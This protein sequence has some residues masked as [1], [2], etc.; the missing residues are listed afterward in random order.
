[1]VMLERA[2]EADVIAIQLNGG[3]YPEGRPAWKRRLWELDS[4]GRYYVAFCEGNSVV[5]R[6]QPG[7]PVPCSPW[8]TLMR[9]RPS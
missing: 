6:R 3:T 7:S 1:M 2:E 5:L 8:E 4:G 9:S